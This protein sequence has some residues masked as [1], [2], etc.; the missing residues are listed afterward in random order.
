MYDECYEKGGTGLP[1]WVWVSEV[2]LVGA[3]VVLGF[4]ALCHSLSGMAD[5]GPWW[6]ATIACSLA[7]GLEVAWQVNHYN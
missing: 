7:F 1:T 6:G 5:A 2:F 4:I 3:T